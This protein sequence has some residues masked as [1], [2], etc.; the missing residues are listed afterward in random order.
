MAQNRKQLEALL[1]FI[2][3]LGNEPGNEWF[4]ERLRK[5][6]GNVPEIPV[7]S[8][9]PQI[10]EIYEYC[11]EKV[12]QAQ[13][14]DFYK[15]IPFENIKET[16]INDFK[17]MEHWRRKDDF[18]EFCMALWQQIEAITNCLANNGEANEA[19]HKLYG[20]T[21]FRTEEGEVTIARY[22]IIPSSNFLEKVDPSKNITALPAIDKMRCVLFLSMYQP[23]KAK[24]F[25]DRNKYRYIAENINS[26][27]QY[28]NLNHRGAQPNERQTKIYEEIDTQTSFYYL[29]FI[30]VL[31]AFIEM[32]ATKPILS[33]EMRQYL[34][35]LP[36]KKYKADI[37]A[38][39]KQVGFIP[40]EE[41]ERRSGTKKRKKI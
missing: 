19:I 8:S 18:Q 15:D 24:A 25:F 5:K 29:K 20:H 36:E 31:A 1:G 23:Y 21:M 40:P 38:D 41:L 10:D 27:Y 14:K 35:N 3:K 37:K 33:D 6:Y 12:I 7:I 26:I 16:L 13:A 4:V 32:V 22:I 11:I 28:R 30:G 34:Q 9:I 39:I 2:E 17:K